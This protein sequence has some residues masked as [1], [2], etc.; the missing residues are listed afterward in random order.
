MVVHVLVDVA[1]EAG[2]DD[3][4]D[5]EGDGHQIHIPVALRVGNLP[6]RDDGLVRQFR[7]LDARQ[8][9]EILNEGRPRQG[10]RLLNHTPVQDM[11]F[12]LHSPAD[13][14][15]GVGDEFVVEDVVVDGV[16]HRAADDA[17][18]EGEGRDGGD[19]VVGADDGC[20]DGGGDD[21]AADAETGE[22]E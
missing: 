10:D 5:A 6:R 4:D 17:D 7:S 1:Q 14:V 15:D 12:Q 20:D 8:H 22:N 3:R 18:G 13:V 11:Q 21:D 16:A 2:A 9:L 19:E